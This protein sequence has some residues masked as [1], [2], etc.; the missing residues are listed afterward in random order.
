MKV[1]IR[2][3]ASP[4]IGTGHLMRCLT[5]ADALMQEGAV[6]SF[7]CSPGAEPWHGLIESHGHHFVPLGVSESAVRSENSAPTYAAWAPWGQVADAT[8]TLGA[9]PEPVDWLIVDHYALDERWERAVRSKAKRILVLDDLADR[10]HDCD[11]LLDHNLQDIAGG[12]Y[13]GLVPG[14]ALCLIGPRYALLRSAFAVERKKRG[15]RGGDVRR[16]VVLLSGTDPSGVTL[17]AIEALSMLDVSPLAVDVLIGT[18]SPH[19]VAIREATERIHAQLHVDSSEVASLF[20]RA[21]LAIGAGGVAALERCC[22]GLPTIAIA[23]A[24]N[25]KP[26]LAWLKRLGAICHLGDFST[27]TVE[28]LTEALYHLCRS[29]AELRIMAERAAAL[30]DGYGTARVAS[31]LSGKRMGVAVRL[32]TMD[33]AEALHRWRNDDAVRAASF[34]GDPIPYGD[35]CRWL[36]GALE[37]DRHIILIGSTTDARAV[38][39]VRYT[40]ADSDAEISIVVDPEI[41]RR[42]VGGE[43]IEAGEA[44]LRAIHPELTRLRAAIKPGNQ[45]SLRLFT[46]AGFVLEVEEPERVLYVKELT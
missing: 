43:L 22:V 42:G 16:I 17:A 35:H 29:P 14:D 34:N 36:A 41:Q 5:L 11:I 9:L 45:A 20:G 2:V 44:Y 21:D 28:R 37:S 13:R 24:E 6:V 33:D 23:I 46:R 39:L 12:R 4:V 30:V 7:L 38:G 1:A 26:G 31:I 10:R 18:A 32:A 3:D 8:A 40:L 19:L 25:Q 27:L 15:P